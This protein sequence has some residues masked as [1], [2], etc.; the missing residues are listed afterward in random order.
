MPLDAKGNGDPASY[1]NS[2]MSSLITPEIFAAL[3]TESQNEPDLPLSQVYDTLV[4]SWVRTLSK[5]IPGGARVAV[6]KRVRKTAAQLYLGNFGVGPI[7][8]SEEIETKRDLETE[9]DTKQKF[10]IAIRGKFVPSIRTKLAQGK[11]EMIEPTLL[12]S[13]IS[14]DMEFL[15]PAKPVPPLYVPKRQ[16]SLDTTRFM[17]SK[18]EMLEEDPASKRLRAL[19]SLTPQSKLPHSSSNILC[20]WIVG[21]DPDNY[22]WDAVKI[23]IELDVENPPEGADEA[24]IKKR[25]EKRRARQEKSNAAIAMLSSNSSLPTKVRAARSPPIPMPVM[26]DSASQAPTIVIA[27]SQ[28]TM[29]GS[30]GLAK[31]KKTAGFR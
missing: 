13:Q 18:A 5:R 2:Q 11:T 27:S 26:Q 7:S 3:S 20:H 25:P 4:K 1:G 23:A 8:E 6:E 12:S 16:S 29:S 9:L 31:K 24:E 17:A 21:S 22:D 10:N 30:G 19:T 14:S 15:A 28:M